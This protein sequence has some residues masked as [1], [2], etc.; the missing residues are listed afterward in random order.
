MK[1]YALLVAAALLAAPIAAHAEDAAPGAAKSGGMDMKSTDM[2]NM[3]G[4]DSGAASEKSGDAAAAPSTRAFEAA[5]AAMMK[6]MTIK[7]SGNADID[8][9]RGMIPHHEGAVEMA[10]IELQYGKDPKLKKLAKAIIAAQEKEISFMK[11][12]LDKHPE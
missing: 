2:K 6:A 11:A 8:F 7:Y 4:M 12:W 9:V 1:R 10:K 5:S 3:E